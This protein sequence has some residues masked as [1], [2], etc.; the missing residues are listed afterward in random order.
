[1]EDY[2]LKNLPLPLPKRIYAK[3]RSDFVKEGNIGMNDVFICLFTG[4]CLQI[5]FSH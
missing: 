2:S 1:M 5:Q 3:G 4:K